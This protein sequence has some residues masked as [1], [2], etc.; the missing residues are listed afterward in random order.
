MKKTLKQL[1]A[2]VVRAAMAEHQYILD[3]GFK[4]APALWRDTIKAE[5]R[6]CARLAAARNGRK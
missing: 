3:A 6:A 1:E 5:F 2:D 4:R